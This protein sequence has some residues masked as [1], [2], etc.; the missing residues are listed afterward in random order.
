MAGLCLLLGGAVLGS[1]MAASV[2]GRVTEIGLRRAI[3]AT[4]A[5][6]V[7]LFATEGMMV[8]VAALVLALAVSL[9]LL[10]T[11]GDRLPLPVE[12]G[13][14][15]VLVPSLIALGTGVLATAAPA[16]H[17]ARIAPAEALRAE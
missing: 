6:I 2:A 5:D 11:L 3:G 17:A 9:L 8:C 7:L 12:A 1:M 14:V 15:A 13:W 16:L 4:P 10:S